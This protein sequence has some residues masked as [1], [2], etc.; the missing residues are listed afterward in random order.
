MDFVGIDKFSLLDYD[1]KVSVV[2][3]SPYCNFSC[4][5]CHNGKSVLNSNTFIPFE[6]II[7]YLKTK[8]GL[9]DAVVFT[10]GEVTFMDDLEE[11]IK[12]VKEL[13]FLT[14]LDTNGTNPFI[15]E[16]LLA[17][18]LL[19]YIAMDIKN[20][21]EEYPKTTGNLIVNMEKIKMSINMIKDS[22]ISYEFRTT[23]VKEFH[24][25]KS[26]EE[27]GKMIEGAEVLYL[28]K[29]VDRDGVIKKGLHEISLE[30]ANQFKEILSKYVKRVE[31][32]GY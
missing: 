32:R 2:L 16:S 26:I 21:E 23:L 11:K 9:V 15:I 10:G 13:G 7:S 4:P 30:E 24:T 31:L 18:N 29:F 8:V 14:K 3:F 17:H 19:D 27:M 28:Q 22:S 6:D 1:E 12:Q 5:F 25:S 20:S